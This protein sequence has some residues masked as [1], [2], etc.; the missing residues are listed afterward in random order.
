[1]SKDIIEIRELQSGDIPD[2]MQLVYSEKWNQTQKDWTILLSN[3]NNVCL[4]A[5]IA[6]EIVA[7][8]TAINYMNQVAWIG[9][10][11]VN[12]QFRGRGISKLLL[13]TL[14]EKLRSCKTIKLDATPAGEFVYKKMGFVAEYKI[15]RMVCSSFTFEVDIDLDADFEQITNGNIDEIVA[16]DRAVFGAGREELIRKLVANNSEN[17][18]LIRENSTLSGFV[19]GREGNRFYQIG[20]LSAITENSTRLLT[21]KVLTNLVGKPVVVVVVVPDEKAEFIEWL[22]SVGFEKRRYFTRMYLNG[23]SSTENIDFQCLICGPEFG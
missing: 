13:N 20:P 7:T 17:S 22:I 3:K 10:V 21:L 2:A 9:M 16:F 14:F 11:L 23:N 5:T 12:K 1:M 15:S 19:L 18:W 8:A 6:G 4:A